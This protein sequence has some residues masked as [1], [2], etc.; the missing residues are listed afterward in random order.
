M[1]GGTRSRVFVRRGMTIIELLLALIILSLLIVGVLGFLG[2][3]LTASTKSTDTTAGVLECQYL[4]D[5]AKNPLENLG[6]PAP[7]GG[8]REGV[9]EVFSHEEHLRVKF[10]YRMNWELIGSPTQFTTIDSDGDSVLHDLQFGSNLYRVSIEMWWMNERPD[11]GRAEG[12]GKRTVNL[13]RFIR[14][15]SHT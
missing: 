8:V 2:S 11:E 6:P 13:E 1:W 12:G 9:R 3:L 4:L 5:A 14:I 10:H 15:E 7:A